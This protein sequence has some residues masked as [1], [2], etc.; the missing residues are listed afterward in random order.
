MV[1]AVHGAVAGAGL[2]VMLS[3]DLVVAE[4]RTKFVFAYQSIGLTP[5]CGV[6]WLL[7]RAIGQQRALSFA[8]GGQSLPADEALTWSM[9]TEVC[10]Q[11]AA[12]GREMATSLAAGPARALGHSRRL[13]RAN[14]ETDR[15]AAGADEARTINEMVQGEEAQELIRRFVRR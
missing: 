10:D 4:P 14:W 3:R 7:P 15:A 11:A 6:S 8:L 9:V 13:L 12:R 1:A 2:A 5:D